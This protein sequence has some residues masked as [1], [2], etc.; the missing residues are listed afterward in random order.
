VGIDDPFGWPDEFV[1]AVHR[2]RETG[3]WPAEIDEPRHVFCLRETDRIVQSHTGKRPLSVSSDRIASPAMR[4]AVLL[5]DIGRHLGSEAVARDGSGLCCAVY[6]DPALRHWTDGMLQPRESYKKAENSSKRTALLEALVQRLPIEDPDDQLA[7]I[8]NEDDHLDALICALV[9]RAVEV[10][11]TI[12]PRPGREM[13][14]AATE[15]WI[16]LPSSPLRELA[17]AAIVEVRA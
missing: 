6:P 5:T 1:D 17:S 16:H 12:Q 2:Y 3:I 15:G 10:G 7:Q 11:Q 13:E 14:R 9:A 8:A 4:C